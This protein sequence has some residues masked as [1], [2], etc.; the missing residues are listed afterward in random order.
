MP[1]AVQKALSFP[2]AG[3]SRLGG[4]RAQ[5]RPYS[6]PWAVNVRGV[7]SIERRG[8]GGSRPGLV[9]V[10]DEDFGA[11][12]LAGV[13]PL[14][15][16][17][18]A[19]VRHDDLIVIADGDLYV[20]RGSTVGVVTPAL[21]VGA[22][23]LTIGGATVVFGSTVGASGAIGAGCHD[24]APLNGRLLLADGV[25]REYEPNCGAVATVMASAGVI[26]AGCP[27]VRVHAGRVFLS[28]ADH[29]WYASRQGDHTDWD[30]GADM[31]DVGRAVA[32][33]CSRAGEIGETI[34]AMI[35]HA[36]GSMMFASRNALWMLQGDPSAGKMV[37]VS[38]EIGV[39]SPT[40]WAKA[41]DGM[42]AF[43]SNDGIYVTGVGSAGH[44]TRFSEGRVPGE[45]RN[46]DPHDTSIVMSYD[47]TGRGFH[48]FITPTAGV[49]DHWWLDMDNK[50]MWP[51]VFSETEHQPV[52]A[53]RLQGAAGDLS[54]VILACRDG[55]L[56]KFSDDA[57]TDDGEPIESHVLLGPFS[58]CSGDT[59]D[60]ILT[61]IHGTL[62]DG[63]GAVEWAILS[64]TSAEAVA[65]LGVTAITSALAG[66]SPTADAEGSWTEA[67]NKV[68]RPRARGAWAVVWLSSAAQWAYESVS[69]VANQLGRLR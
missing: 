48:L 8:R 51:V 30:F 55:F 4:Y 61:E 20:L 45:L 1:K 31:G 15:S 58:L 54:E 28:G 2:L 3:V 14:S 24:A 16:V 49:G 65:D 27:L 12:H 60:G 6:A 19:G 46:V 52:A 25:L 38:S 9:L 29:L 56:R 53:S 36:D 33:Q 64:D 66:G 34:T 35:P 57:T 63:S 11:G 26:P 41:P 50:A 40:A 5:T 37:Q 22:S 18:G 68:S 69:I 39:L 13:F 67:R 21:A 43:L 17:D 44:P 10:D 62:A 42:V 32:G 23:V 7:C 47:I 59:Q